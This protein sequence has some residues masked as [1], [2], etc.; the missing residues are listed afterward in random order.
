MDLTKTGQFIAVSRKAQGITQKE[1]A[2]LI[3]VT[4]KAVSRWETGKGF[5]D[6]SVLKA[7]S[8]ALGVSITEIVNGEKTS[9]ENI[10]EKSDSAVMGT[11]AYIGRMTEKTIAVVV[12]VVGILAILSPL[13]IAVKSKTPWLL[14]IA[15]AGAVLTAVSLVFL[16]RKKPPKK[17]KALSKLAA[18]IISLSAL[19]ITVILELLPWGVIMYFADG[20]GRLVTKTCSYFNMLPPGYGNPFPLLTGVLTIAV[21]VL[22]VISLLKKSGGSPRN[23]TFICTITDLG[24]CL[25]SA[26]I[27]KGSMALVGIL[28]SVLLGVS[29]VFQ[30]Y[31]ASRDK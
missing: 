30:A 25:L 17:R 11:L 1:L 23:V 7:L 16:L 19:A 15:G 6:V 28:I 21:T 27:F 18:E 26:V 3:G 12:F 8:G 20:S 22:S 14:I 9:A 10:E 24:F 13:F 5:P 2:D 4:D 31:A 29:V